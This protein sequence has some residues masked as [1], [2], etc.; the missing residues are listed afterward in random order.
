MAI[1][2]PRVSSRELRSIMKFPLGHY[3]TVFSVPLGTVGVFNRVLDED[4]AKVILVQATRY[5]VPQCDI[6]GV[7]CH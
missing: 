1:V 2:S 6:D 3:E 4:L 7:P 5:K